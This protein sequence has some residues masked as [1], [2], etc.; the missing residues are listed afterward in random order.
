AAYRDMR[1]TPVRSP[2]RTTCA[3]V[4]LLMR[5]IDAGESPGA[6]AFSCMRASLRALVL[7]L[8]SMG[9]ASLASGQPARPTTPSATR[10]RPPAVPL[11]AVDPYFSIWSPADRL[12]DAATVHWTGHPHPLASLIRVDG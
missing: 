12:T 11:V 7:T 9:A 10:L 4:A 1:S 5:G 8:V 2:R 3:F 6:R